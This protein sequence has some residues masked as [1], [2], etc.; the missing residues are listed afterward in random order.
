MIACFDGKF[1]F[2]K[3]IEFLVSI[4]RDASCGYRE[5]AQEMVARNSIL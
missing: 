3:N 2:N 4:F 5:G 1:K